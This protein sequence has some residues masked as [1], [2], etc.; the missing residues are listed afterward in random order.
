MYV[1]GPIRLPIW[2]SYLFCLW[3][4]FNLP[5]VAVLKWSKKYGNVFGCYL[6]DFIAV[7]VC[8]YE[9]CKEVL[10]RPEFDGKPDLMNARLRTIG[11]QKLG[12][13]HVH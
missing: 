10:N 13:I 3:E 6:A 5:Q 11:V 4:N 12:N 7:F 8:D 9:T 2:G 1:T